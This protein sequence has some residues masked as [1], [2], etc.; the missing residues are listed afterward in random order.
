MVARDQDHI[1]RDSRIAENTK[2]IE[3]LEKPKVKNAKKT[4]PP[5][6]QA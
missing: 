3:A 5:K 1:D 6:V 4:K 2:R